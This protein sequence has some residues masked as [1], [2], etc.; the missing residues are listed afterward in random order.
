MRPDGLVVTVVEPLLRA[1][2]GETR[3]VYP[4]P[5]GP[6]CKPYAPASEDLRQQYPVDRL[7]SVVGQPVLDG[8]EALGNAAA[9]FS[10]ANDFG[11]VGRLPAEGPARRDGLFDFRALQQQVEPQGPT[12]SLDVAWRNVHRSWYEDYEFLRALVQL[13]QRSDNSVAILERV[14]AYSRWRM[15]GKLAEE[16]FRDIVSRAGVPTVARNSLIR[17]FKARYNAR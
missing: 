9:V 13:E 2:V 4:L 17:E 3:R 11:H 1:K 14:L 10:E 16:R 8:S 12:F 5:D 6:D 15:L 7:V